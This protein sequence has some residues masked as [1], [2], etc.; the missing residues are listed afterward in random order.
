M[1]S[2]AARLPFA[3]GANVTLIVQPAPAATLAPQLFDWVKSLE[4]DPE[5]EMLVMVNAALPVVVRVTDSGVLEVPTG[6]LPKGTLDGE[7]LAAEDA[8]VPERLTACG[9]PIALSAMASE[10]VRLPLAK[11]VKVML[12]AQLEPAA[13]LDP[14]LLDWVKSPAFEPA[15]ETLVMFNGALPVLLRVT[16]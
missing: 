13:T 10:A 15:M 14:Q 16:D 1:A 7:T 4:F 12:M 3:A 9:L 8:P 11:G 6:T 2:E 5:N